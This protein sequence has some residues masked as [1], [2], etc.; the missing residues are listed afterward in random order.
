MSPWHEKEV[1]HVWLNRSRVLRGNDPEALRMKAEELLARW[2]EDWKLR[3]DQEQRESLEQL[4]KEARATSSEQKIAL[5]EDKTVE[6]EREIHKLE[7]ILLNGI[8]RDTRIDWESL[9]DNSEFA[10]PRPIEPRLTLPAL[11]ALLMPPPPV[12]PAKP[13]MPDKPIQPDPSE[14][15]SRSDPRFQV[16]LSDLEHERPEVVERKRKATESLYIQAALVWN[17]KVRAHNESVAKFNDTISKLRDEYRSQIEGYRKSKARYDEECKRLREDYED[18][19]KTTNIVY[20]NDVIREQVK[21]RKNMVQ[22][23]EERS[24]FYA[25]REKWNRRVDERSEGYFRCISED[26]IEYCDMVLSRSEY[27]KHFPQRF[28]CDY[29]KE[30]KILLCD[31]YLPGLEDL[32]KAREWKYVQSRDALISIPLSESFREK[33]YD[34]LVCQIT[35]KVMHDLFTADTAGASDSIVFN[36]RVEAI[37][38]ATGQAIKPCILSVHARKA[39]FADLNLTLVEPKACIRKLK[40]VASSRLHQLA[41]VAPILQ[42]DRGDK[43]FV[44]LVKSRTNLSTLQTWRRWIGRTSSI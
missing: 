38:K 16:A 25:R 6:A 34:S 11:Q 7:N 42:I 23:E 18:R 39:E 15:P 30:N 1:R 37:D 27:P 9:K 35:L 14:R 36:G 19:L 43:Q 44:A 20:Q 29:V 8:D 41:P 22:W 10:R 4:V 12:E 33:L 31:Y 5:A 24:T 17:S 26:V 40:G 32:P 21:Y 2:D 3:R 13:K 28:D